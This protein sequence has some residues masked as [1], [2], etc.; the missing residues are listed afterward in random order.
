M[1]EKRE[2]Y[3][4]IVKGIAIILM[5]IGHF[6]EMKY[7]DI[8]KIIFIFIYSFHMPLFFILSGY[9]FKDHYLDNY[10][11]FLKKRVCRLLVPLVFFSIINIMVYTFLTYH[12]TGVLCT[13]NIKIWMLGIILEDKGGHYYSFFWF[14]SCLF[15]AENIFWIVRKILANKKYSYFPVVILIYLCGTFIAINKIHVYWGIDMALVAVLFMAIGRLY[16]KYE[17]EMDKRRNYI[18]NILMLLIGIT[19][20]FINYYICKEPINMSASQ[21]NNWILFPLIASVNSLNIINIS[22]RICAYNLKIKILTFIG[23]NSL[24]FYVLSNISL[25]IP[26]FIMKKILCT[27]YDKLGNKGILLVMILEPLHLFV[28]AIC[29]LIIN[30]KFRWLTGDF[31]RKK[32]RKI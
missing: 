27:N 9:N 20:P 23:E 14:L 30:K 21:I 1:N 29:V 22:K 7:G 31:K 17:N 12:H 18:F 6:S 15:L 13:S 2:K 19:G 24:L 32:S 8:Q 4:D 3:I 5:Y 16:K 10:I 11:A 25:L 26:D 28:S